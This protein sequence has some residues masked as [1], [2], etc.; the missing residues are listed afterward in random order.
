MDALGWP[1][2]RVTVT[3]TGPLIDTLLMLALPASGKSVI[4]RFLSRLSPE[5]AASDFYLGP[6]VQLD[7]FPY[8][9]FMIRISESMEDMG[10]E[11]A[12]IAGG[13][14]RDLGDWGT[15]IHLINEDYA[16]LGR[17]IR[18]IERPPGEWIM[19]RLE[20]ARARIGMA[21]PFSQLDRE[22]RRVTAMAIEHEA[23]Q[24]AA[25]WSTRSR[26][27]SGTVVIEF[28]RGGPDDASVPLSPPH[29]YAYSLSQLSTEILQR[30]VVL[31]VWVTPEDSRRRNRERAKPGGEGSSLH[32]CV[33]EEV[34]RSNFGTDDMR[35]LV[36]HGERVGRIS[37][38]TSGST[39]HLP[40]AIYDNR[41]DLM[42]FQRRDPTTWPQDEVAQVRNA[43][44]EAFETLATPTI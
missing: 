26:P 1:E 30:A 28:S 41:D 10:H 25:L 18:T 35:W 36:D 27:P 23:A 32:H 20:A 9:N 29:G 43:L 24:F 34:M 5:V 38:H 7:D 13:A 19:D 12:F 17:P 37:V 15:L 4:R 11:P 3:R 44:A 39:F 33:P 42:M 31:Y 2:S 21:A 22:Q 16:A 14:F 6:L 8:V 40:T